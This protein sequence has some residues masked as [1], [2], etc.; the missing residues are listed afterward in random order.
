MPRPPRLKP[1]DHSLEPGEGIVSSVTHW[2]LRS[3]CAHAPRK[4]DAIAP[5][6][7]DAMSSSGAPMAPKRAAGPFLALPSGATARSQRGHLERAYDDFIS[8]GSVATVRPM[9]AESWRLSRA[10]GVSPD[11]VLP[12]VDMLD[13]EL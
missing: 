8:T 12:S 11:G 2:P 4:V 7:A 10:S 9:V 5:G 1:A 3:R 13:A 6:A